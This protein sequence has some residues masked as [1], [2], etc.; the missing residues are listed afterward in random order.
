MSKSNVFVG[1]GAEGLASGILTERGY[2]IIEHN[3][4]SRFGEIDLVAV[5]D[6]TLYFVE[7][8][9]RS[10]T[11]FGLPEEAVTQSKLRKITKTAE[12]Y[13]L[14]HPGLPQKLRI[15][16]VAMIIEGA[17]VENYKLIDVF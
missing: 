9:A 17:K 6:K 11:R 5:K 3:F 12:Y 14:T 7:V 2:K 13:C 10:G 4:R 1:L 8:K 16:V 15:I